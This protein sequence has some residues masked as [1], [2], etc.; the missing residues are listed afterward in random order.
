[1]VGVVV[2]VRSRLFVM[3]CTIYVGMSLII[4]RFDYCCSYFVLSVVS[5]VVTSSPEIKSNVSRSDSHVSEYEVRRLPTVP[6]FMSQ[7][8]HN[9]S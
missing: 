9:L 8:E 5:A 7:D 4:I 1:M 6:L 3:Y 2:V